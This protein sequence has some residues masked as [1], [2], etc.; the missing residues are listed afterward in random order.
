MTAAPVRCAI[1]VARRS[2]RSERGEKS[3]ARSILSMAVPV[4]V[5]VRSPQARGVASTD[6]SF[7]RYPPDGVRQVIGHYQGAPRVHGDTHGTTPRRAVFVL[8]T[9]REVERFTGLAKKM[10]HYC[11]DELSR[12]SRELS[13]QDTVDQASVEG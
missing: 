4:V 7:G 12:L 10:E 2:A 11:I 8:K 13:A 3:V 9:G 5:A 6:S 1:S